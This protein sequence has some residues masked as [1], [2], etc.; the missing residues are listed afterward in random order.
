MRK[1]V[2]AMGGLL[3]WSRVESI[4]LG[5]TVEREGQTVDIVI[6]KKRPQKIRATITMPIP[7]RED[8]YLQLIRAH[9]GKHA[10]TATR[11]AGSQDIVKTELTGDDAND[12][13][14]DAGV[15]PR[16]IHLWRAGQPLRLAASEEFD[17]RS[18]YVIEVEQDDGATLLRFYLD[19]ESFRTIAREV[20]SGKAT[21][22]THFSAYKENAGVYLPTHSEI[23]AE[24]T[25]RSIVRTESIQIGVGIYEEYFGWAP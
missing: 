12:L 6:V 20:R 15:L 17:D 22:T 24:N 11:L 2:E 19:M 4:R 7:D 14:A 23:V 1:H 18:V 13:L 9:D 16:L 25:G 3:N 5:G 10:W 21:V 8:E